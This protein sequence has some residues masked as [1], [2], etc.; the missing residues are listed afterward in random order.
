VLKTRSPKETSAHLGSYQLEHED[1][2]LFGHDSD[3]LLVLGCEM[4]GIVGYFVYMRRVTTY[5]VFESSAENAQDAFFD[6]N[7]VEIDS[8]TVA[9]DVETE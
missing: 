7:A 9:C 6:D 4:L 1:F 8:E 3:E 5:R 2:S